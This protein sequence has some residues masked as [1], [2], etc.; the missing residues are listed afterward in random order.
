MNIVLLFLCGGMNQQP[1]LNKK[2]LKR[3]R[4]KLAE[5]ECLLCCRIV[6]PGVDDPAASPELRQVSSKG[7]IYGK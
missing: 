6:T 7:W 4:E 5:G 3:L 1:S 2:W